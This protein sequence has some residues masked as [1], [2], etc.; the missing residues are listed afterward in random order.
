MRPTEDLR[1]EHRAVKLMLRILDSICMNIE[2]GKNIEQEHLERLVEF[3]KVFVDRCH[4]T[5][6]EAYLFPEMKKAEIPGAREL[7]DSLLKE[8]KQGR[9]YASKIGEAVSG[10]KWNRTG[11]ALVENS[12]AYIQLLTLHI[13]K[14]DNDLF[15]R[16]DT[17]LGS[18]VQEKLLDSFEVVEKEE[19][20]EG[21]HEEFHML[22]HSLKDMYVKPE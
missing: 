5:K 12:R 7:I 13:E 21:K 19:I 11:S 22:L 10:K 18:G 4:H 3:M 9:E 16:A 14:E 6:E 8:H 15:P 20:G 1:E 2:S 17:Y